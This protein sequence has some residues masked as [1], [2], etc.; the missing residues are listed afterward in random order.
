MKRAPHGR[1]ALASRQLGEQVR[2]GNVRPNLSKNVATQATGPAARAIDAHHIVREL[3]DRHDPFRTVS[4]L[5]QP[6]RITSL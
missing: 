5:R 3:I 1:E 6:H 2:Q 4:A